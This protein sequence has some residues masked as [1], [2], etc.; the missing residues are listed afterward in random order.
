MKWV[1]TFLNMILGQFAREIWWLFKTTCQDR[2]DNCWE[3]LKDNLKHF[4]NNFFVH[5]LSSIF[6]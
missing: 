4:W 1:K 5:M 6:Y 3:V 2:G